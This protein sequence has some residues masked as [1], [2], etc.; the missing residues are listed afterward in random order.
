MKKY[1]LTNKLPASH[2]EMC[3]SILVMPPLTS[4]NRCTVC[5][6]GSSQHKTYTFGSLLQC[7][8]NSACGVGGRLGFSNYILT[9]TYSIRFDGWV[10]KYRRLVYRKQWKTG[11]GSRGFR[12][13]GFPEGE[14]FGYS[15]GLQGRGR[16]F[17]SAR[18]I[19]SGLT[20]SILHLG[21]DRLFYS[22]V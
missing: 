11:V 17:V 14:A 18:F 20:N 15:D 4:E 7:G 9:H 12:P 5:C 21:F 8:E 10:G 3:I 2:C 6:F 1:L 19:F 16:G 13:V 22:S